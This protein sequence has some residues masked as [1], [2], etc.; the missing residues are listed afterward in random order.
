MTGS[1]EAKLHVPDAG[2]FRVRVRYCECDPMAVAHHSAYVPWLEE[3][4]T[5]LLRAC[6]VSYAQLEAE[7]VLLAVVRLEVTYR[8]PARYD[9][10]L[11]VRVRVVGGSRV[12][13][14]HEYEVVLAERSGASAGEVAAMEAH[15]EALLARAATTLACIGADG[16]PRALP[17]WLVPRT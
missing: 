14:R 12:K 8:R 6:G 13:I 10:V 11:E 9:D 1:T 17:D 3:A 15:G 5:E 7:G 16:R 2:S 4:R